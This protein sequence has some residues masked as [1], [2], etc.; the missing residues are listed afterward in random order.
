MPSDPDPTSAA[1]LTRESLDALPA[2]ERQSALARALRRRACA[3]LG[4]AERALGL[5][6]PLLDLGL[7]SLAAIELAHGVETDFGIELPLEAVFDGASCAGLAEIL[8]RAIAEA[9]PPSPGGREGVGEGGQGG[10]APWSGLSSG[11][12]G[13]WLLD[14]LLPADDASYRLAAA[15][16]LA[17]PVAAPALRAA[18]QRLVDRHE[19]LRTTYAADDVTGEP[20]RRVAASAEVAFTEVDA[21][22]W[23]AERLRL[24]IEDEAW[25]P[26]DLA[27]GP[28][29]RV[30]LLSG[31]AEGPILVVAIHHIVADFRS[32]VLLA[33][34]LGSYLQDRPPSREGASPST[35]LGFAP[36]AAKDEELWA[37]WRS[38]LADLPP[39]VS[40]P[41]DQAP[42]PGERLSGPAGTVRIELGA[43]R[44]ERLLAL[45]RR[46]G[47]TLYAA[48]FAAY[49]SLLAR[50]SGTTDLTVGSPAAGRP[51][52]PETVGY[53]VNPLVLRLGLDGDPSFT[54]VLARAGR[55]LAGALAHQEMPLPLLVERLRQE[56]PGAEIEPFRTMLML[57]QAPAGQEG[58]VS[59]ALGEEAGTLQLGPLEL[60][61]WPLAPRS[62][63]FDLTASFGLR[64][65]SLGGLLIYHAG[66]FEA[67]D[68]APLRRSARDAPRWRAAGAGTAAERSLSPLRRGTA[69][70]RP[71]SE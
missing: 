36:L 16:R 3:A 25:R 8:L 49:G 34:Q 56:R 14:R 10:E 42:E 1:S 55:T 33:R 20:V 61:P 32:L 68:H 62:A 27:Q 43:E 13:L 71:G 26:F 59:L 19:A 18:F 24:A 46:Q 69:P 31:S 65:G 28:L 60:K 38:R 37:Y 23:S 6:Q 4:V 30:A 9:I 50:L 7:D 21:A 67:V 63:Q 48:L 17:G 64:S 44:T 57:Y 66:R 39:G 12:H 15:A 53:F 40:L 11:E 51:E 35:T 70:A 58:L 54:E 29:F 2:A 45:A 22:G 5:D 52:A 41:Y 47:V